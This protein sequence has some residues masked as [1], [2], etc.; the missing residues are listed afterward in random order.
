MNAKHVVLLL[1]GIITL[2]SVLSFLQL[3]PVGGEF[4]LRVLGI[5]FMFY[6]LYRARIMYVIFGEERRWANVLLLGTC[7]LASARTLVSALTEP[8]FD[9]L[10]T[11]VLEALTASIDDATMYAIA[12]VLFLCL[13]AL[14]ASRLH[15]R[16]PSV[17]AMIGESGLPRTPYQSIVRTILIAILLSAFYIVVFDITLQ[18][19][20][21]ILQTASI[22][23]IVGILIGQTLRHPKA[24]ISLGDFLLAI[25]DIDSF[26]YTKLVR[27]MHSRATILFGVAALLVFFPLSDLG[28]FLVP[29]TLNVPNGAF[30]Q[31]AEPRLHSPLSALAY[32]SALALGGVEAA[33][34]VVAYVLNAV[35]AIMVLLLPALL[36][37]RMF[38]KRTLTLSP[39]G[40]AVFIACAL[41]FLLAPA[42]ALERLSETT[43]TMVGVDIQTR[44]LTDQPVVAAVLI[45]VAAGI[46]TYLLARR[47]T[48]LV[49]LVVVLLSLA[50]LARYV[51]LYFTDVWNDLLQNALVFLNGAGSVNF[52]AGALFLSF[53]AMSV[54]FYVGALASY[55]YEVW[56]SLWHE[57]HVG[58]RHWWTH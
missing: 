8:S 57:H 25:E 44:P 9:N 1:L 30:E 14:F 51:L 46:V 52:I 40:S 54:L 42:F 32:E 16:K 39:L 11:V 3:L 28:V 34:A 55:L 21:V 45:S 38:R 22:V 15:V 53:L 2:L 37:L 49:S 29:Y 10:V 12:G 33:A 17:M 56:V 36:W 7:A 43:T 31:L 48:V 50:F 23:I 19:W 26:Y 5:T 18:W 41:C 6:V 24:R 58:K 27:L 13:G 47:L 35:G 4:V 20:G